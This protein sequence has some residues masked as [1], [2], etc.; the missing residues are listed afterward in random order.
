MLL[1]KLVEVSQ[2]EGMTLEKSTK[3][4]VQRIQQ[5]KQTN[6]KPEAES[7][8]EENKV[9]PMGI[10]EQLQQQYSVMVEKISQEQKS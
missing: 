9:I 4:I 6:I 5:S 3:L 8:N 2:H 1:E 7:T 10:Q